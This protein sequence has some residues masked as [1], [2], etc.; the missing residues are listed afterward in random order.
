M[1]VLEQLASRC[2]RIVEQFDNAWPIDRGEVRQALGEAWHVFVGAN[3]ELRN[4][5]PELAAE[6]R[7]LAER[8]DRASSPWLAVPKT[9]PPSLITTTRT[10]MYRLVDVLVHLSGRDEFPE[11]CTCVKHINGDGVSLSISQH[12]FSRERER[13]FWRW[14]CSCRSKG[15]WSQS[16]NSTYHAWMKHAEESAVCMCNEHRHGAD[17][18]IGNHNFVVVSD[19]GKHRW[20][21]SCWPDLYGEW[22]TDRMNVY[23]EWLRHAQAIYALQTMPVSGETGIDTG[24]PAV[25]E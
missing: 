15:G 20:R 2:R 1:G 6:L 7:A 21:C 12:M 17:V 10:V 9:P 3:R 14:A 25:V 8:L 24:E 5:D 23:H 13:G 11:V 22:K 16:P 4:T 18:E 19:N